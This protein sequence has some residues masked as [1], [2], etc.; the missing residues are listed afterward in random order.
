MRRRFRESTYSWLATLAIGLAL[1]TPVAWAG[2]AASATIS[3][4]SISQSLRRILYDGASPSGVTDLRAMQD[5]VKKISEVLKKCTVGVQ[6]GPAGVAHEQRVA[7][8]H[9]P[10]SLAAGEVR[11][12]VGVV[13]ARMAWRGD[14]RRT[15][16][17]QVWS[18]S[19][20]ARL[21][22]LRGAIRPGGRH[23]DRRLV[24]LLQ[25][26]T[27]AGSPGGG[28]ADD[29]RDGKRG[30]MPFHGLIL[31]AEEEAPPERKVPQRRLAK[32]CAQPVRHYAGGVAPGA[33]SSTLATEH[34]TVPRPAA[35]TAIRSPAR[36]QPRLVHVR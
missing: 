6:V 2:D 31:R 19:C 27:L 4:D 36:R 15:P 18:P 25:Q 29:R 7:G 3:S 34:V 10:R 5:H 11:D 1:M 8:Q 16:R 24:A 28:R 20:C 26:G 12:Q 32:N 22:S 17:R 21:H 23:R 14:R 9:E 35:L 30:R 13:G 33:P